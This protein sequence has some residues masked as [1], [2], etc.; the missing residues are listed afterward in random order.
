MNSISLTTAGP[1]RRPRQKR[2]QISPVDLALIAVTLVWGFNNIVV[3]RALNSFLPLS[4]NA[5]RFSFATALIF[6]VL[7]VRERKVTVPRGDLA[8]LFFIGFLGNT[9]YQIGFIKGLDLSTAGNVSFVLSTMPATTALIAH[10]MGIER[11]PWR[12]WLGLGV[13]LAGAVLIVASTGG[14]FEFGGQAVRGDLIVLAG[15]LGWCLYTILS[16]RLV[17]RFTPLRLTAWTMGLGVLTLV[18]AS[19]P[20]ILRQ[21]WARPDMTAWL[22]LAGSATFALVFC[23]VVWNWGLQRLGTARTA[24]YGNITPLWTGLFGWLLLDETW[25]PTRVGGG[26]LILAGVAIVRRA[27]ARGAAASGPGAQAGAGG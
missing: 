15:T 23:Y 4:F 13:T 6:V 19:L 10:L 22:C 5:L 17:D 20:D 3:K 14:R 25:P 16:K 11:L 2:A 8:M 12:G 18:P 27:L 1:H 21:D 26:L 9:V 24:I 7:Y